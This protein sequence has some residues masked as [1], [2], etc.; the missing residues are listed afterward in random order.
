MAKTPFSKK[1]PSVYKSVMRGRCIFMIVSHQSLQ[2][3]N[4]FPDHVY[5]Q[6]KGNRRGGLE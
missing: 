1:P 4:N 2:A 6:S 3:Q 5:P